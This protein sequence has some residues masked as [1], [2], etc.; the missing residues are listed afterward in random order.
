MHLLFTDEI[1]FLYRKSFWGL[2]IK[3][4]TLLLKKPNIDIIFP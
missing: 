4:I 3:A 1:D 2:L